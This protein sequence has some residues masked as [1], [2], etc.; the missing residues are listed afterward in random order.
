M[1][2][3][4]LFF[5]SKLIFLGLG[6]TVISGILQ[7]VDAASKQRRFYIT[8]VTYNG[9]EALLAC[10]PWFSHGVAMGDL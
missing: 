7:T 2:K 9:A 1:V 6:L 3:F 8:P 4:K 10:A 5:V